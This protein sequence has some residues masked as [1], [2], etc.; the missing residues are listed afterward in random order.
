MSMKLSP[1][2]TWKVISPFEMS[3]SLLLLARVARPWKIDTH[4][5]KYGGQPK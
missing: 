3:A 2:F 1:D 4:S 5:G